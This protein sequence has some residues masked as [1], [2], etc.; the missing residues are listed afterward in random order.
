[1]K[2]NKPQWSQAYAAVYQAETKSVKLVFWKQYLENYLAK[3]L[4]ARK[5]KRLPEQ[6]LVYDKKTQGVRLQLWSDYL[7]VSRFYQSA[8]YYS[9]SGGAKKMA[10]YLYRQQHK[11]VTKPFFLGHPI[12]ESPRKRFCFRIISA[13]HYSLPSALFG[14]LTNCISILS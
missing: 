2:T 9:I 4:E 6:T 7:K 10:K 5:P 13:L 1:M 3:D 12:R 14:L 11:V 8:W